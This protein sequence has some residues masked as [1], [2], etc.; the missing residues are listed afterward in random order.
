MIK[1]MEGKDWQKFMKS[2]RFRSFTK[3]EINDFFKKLGE[4][5]KKVKHTA[6]Y[7]KLDELYHEFNNIPFNGGAGA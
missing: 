6:V 1:I 4:V 2:P 5:D 7:R 3:K